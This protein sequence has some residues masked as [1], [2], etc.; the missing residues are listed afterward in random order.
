VTG[1]AYLT[2]ARLRILRGAVYGRHGGPDLGVVTRQFIQGFEATAE[3]R[4]IA[5][6]VEQGLL[7]PNPH[8][9]WYITDAG[10]E[11]AEVDACGKVLDQ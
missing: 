6:L 4:N 3:R 1:A 5:W 11:A 8:G 7:K 2:S 10:K 9:D